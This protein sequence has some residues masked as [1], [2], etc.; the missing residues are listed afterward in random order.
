MARFSHNSVLKEK[1][2]IYQNAH[3]KQKFWGKIH[4]FILTWICIRMLPCQSIRFYDAFKKYT[5]RQWHT[6][7][8][9]FSHNSVLK[10]K[11]Q[12]YQ[13]AHSKQKFWGKIHMFILTWICTRMLPCEYIRFYDEFKNYTSHQWHTFTGSFSHSSVLKEKTQNYQNACAKQKLWSKIPMF[14]ITWICTRMLLSEYIRFY[15]EF[16]KY[17]SRRWHTFKASFSYATV[18][19]EK[20]PSYQM[21]VRSKNFWRKFPMF[22]LTHICNRMPLHEWNVVLLFIFANLP[23]TMSTTSKNKILLVVQQR[24]P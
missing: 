8:A 1:I 7:M 11:I 4:M 14:I 17:T 24:G 10:G 12:I 21:L 18:L 15:D 22:I 6:F 9:R 16:K 5:S 3:S 13:N 23:P 20:T 2:Q 19:T